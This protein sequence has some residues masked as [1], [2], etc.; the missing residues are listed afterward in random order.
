LLNC[1]GKVS[2]RILARRLSYLAET[3]TLLHPSQIGSRLYKSAIDAALLLKNEVELNKANKLKTSTLFL[4]IKGAF[5]HVSKNRLVAILVQLKLPTS[6]INWITSFLEN[7][8]LRLAFNNSIEEFSTINTG[9]PQGSPISPILFLIYIRDLFRSN[10]VYSLSY[11]DDI[12]LIASS[13]SF[14]TNIK[15]LERE[16]KRLVELGE[17]SAIKF[18]IDKTELIH[19]NMDKRPLSLTLPNGAIIAPNRLV[20]WLGIH[21]DSSLKFKEHIAIRTSLAKQ[22]L[23]RFNRLCN[24]SR[25]LSLYAIR[26]L[27]LACVTS[28]S[29]YGSILWWTKPNKAQVRPLQAIQNLA[30]RKILGVFKTAPI[31]PMELEAALLPP[32][33]RLNHSNRRY[34]F[35]VL[36]LSLSH[37]IRAE[38]EKI[39]LSFRTDQNPSSSFSLDPNWQLKKIKPK[40]TTFYGLVKSIYNLIDFTNLEPIRHFYFTPWDRL[41]PYNIVISNK[42]KIEEAKLH[43]EYLKTKCNS[44]TISIY[45]DGSQTAKGLGIGLG[46]VAYRHNRL[47]TLCQPIYSKLENIGDESI[48]YNG[49]LEAITKA[50]EYASYIAKEGERFNIFTDNQAS[51]LR[52]K[53]PSDRPGQSQQIRAIIATNTIIS[54]GAIVDLIWVPGHTD[55]LGNEEADRLA[56]LATSSL[57]YLVSNKTSFAYLGIRINQLKKLEIN[58]ILGSIKKPRYL[59]SYSNTYSWRVSNKILVPRGI[60]RELASSIFQLKL[61]HGYLKSYLYRLNIIANNKYRC[62]LEET[63]KHLLLVCKDYKVQR[64]ALL[65]SIRTKI[66]VR[67]LTLPL[68]L[69]TNIGISS[70]VVFLKETR[71]CTRNWHLKRLEEEEE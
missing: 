66:E 28:V 71:L 40:K 29:D 44:K 53:S 46:L 19:F 51:L 9:I 64:K 48:V 11:M 39:I 59:D 57:D 61:G 22:A 31:I 15:I 38:L 63:T 16:S 2:E 36:K 18:D 67:V 42:S 56:K 41:V 58:S 14:K 13:K 6:L 49:E 20:R 70:L 33:V 1:L 4:D 17:Q 65:E 25:G 60:K 43:L 7:R 5:D 23:Y 55:I 34:M 47:N 24:I 8:V 26:Q 12:A 62:G 68:I 21:F 54:K 3:T 32:I 45:T 30:L 10:S 50:L 69:H 27:Y 52:L 37:P 35:R